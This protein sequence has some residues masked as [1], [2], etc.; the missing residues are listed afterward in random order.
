MK[1]DGVDGKA[2]FQQVLA[3]TREGFFADPLYGGNRNMSGWNMIGF[4]GARYDYRDWVE[5]HNERF[6]LPP[7]SI[8]G[9]PE[10]EPTTALPQ[11]S[12]D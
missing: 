1:F 6:P 12:Q 7:V 11:H 4:P 9:R 10:W 5:R 2:F 3:N 8:V